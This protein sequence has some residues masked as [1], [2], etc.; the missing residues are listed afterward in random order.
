[1]VIVILQNIF[2]YVLQKK[3]SSM[4]EMTLGLENE[5]N[6]VKLHLQFQHIKNNVKCKQKHCQEM[7]RDLDV[8]VTNHVIKHN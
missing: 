1:M 7:K 5:K 4:F 6:L 2:C 8:T 3:N